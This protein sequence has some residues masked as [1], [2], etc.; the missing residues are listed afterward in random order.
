MSFTVLSLCLICVYLALLWVVG[1][2]LEGVC[3]GCF[4]NSLSYF[5]VLFVDSWCLGSY[6]FM[7]CFFKGDGIPLEFVLAFFGIDVISVSSLFYSYIKWVFMFLFSAECRTLGFYESTD[8]FYLMLVILFFLSS[9]QM[10]STFSIAEK[11]VL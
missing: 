4:S 8:S 10:F 7:F 11:G 2:S 9:L 6:R 1:F 3:L 5:L